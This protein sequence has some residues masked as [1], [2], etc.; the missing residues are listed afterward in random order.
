V[1]SGEGVEGEHLVLGVLEQSGDLG[2]PVLEV[3]DRF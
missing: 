1:I 2:E 3:R